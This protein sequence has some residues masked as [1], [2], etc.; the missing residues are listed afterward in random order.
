ME[1]SAAIEL[2]EILFDYQYDML[3]VRVGPWGMNHV[4]FLFDEAASIIE[5]HPDLKQWAM[6]AFESSIRSGFEM[7]LGFPK[8]PAGFVTADF[9]LYMVHRTRWCEFRDLAKRLEG[10][11]VDLWRSN[12]TT[13]WS[14]AIRE[15]IDDEWE[16]R[17]FFKRFAGQV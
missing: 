16:D 4:E 17:E 14:G 6:D 7:R 3:M 15:A 8:R 12:L 1:S 9:I 5:T 10:S 2:V 13:R 11:S